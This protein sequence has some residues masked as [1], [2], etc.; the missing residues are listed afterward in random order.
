M[1]IK[2][3]LSY[4]VNFDF[5]RVQLPKYAVYAILPPNKWHAKLYAWIED[6]RPAKDGRPFCVCLLSVDDTKPRRVCV[7][8][9]DGALYRQFVAFIRALPAE[10]VQRPVFPITHKDARAVGAPNSRTMPEYKYKAAPDYSGAI[11][12]ALV[13]HNCIVGKVRLTQDGYARERLKVEW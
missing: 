11:E 5:G 12:G 6:V 9:Q 1:I 13:T 3:A 7:T 2:Q 4:S 10:R 8:A